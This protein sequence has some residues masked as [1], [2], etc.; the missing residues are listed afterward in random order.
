MRNTAGALGKTTVTFS[1]NNSRPVLIYAEN[2]ALV[3]SGAPQIQGG[4]LIDATCTAT[5]A[6]T[7]FGHFSFYSVA[8]PFPALNMTLADSAAVRTALAPLAPRVLLVSATA[9]R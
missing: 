5:G 8:S 3:F 6:V 1:G 2:C 7:W 4:L 9:I